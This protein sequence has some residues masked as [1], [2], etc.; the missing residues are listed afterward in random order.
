MH[1]AALLG[2]L[3]STVT[4]RML[5]SFPSLLVTFIGDL[6]FFIILG[7]IFLFCSWDL[8]DVVTSAASFSCFFILVFKGCTC[9]ASFV[10][11]PDLS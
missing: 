11:V 4:C 1:Q 5:S 6:I 3:E 8:W 9:A 7:V 2:T 10:V